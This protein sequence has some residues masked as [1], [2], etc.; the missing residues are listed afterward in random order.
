ME[1]EK[2]HDDNDHGKKEVTIIVNTREKKWSEKEISYKQVVIL[3]FDVFSEDENVVYTVTFTRGEESRH[4]G[5]LV[6]GESVKVKEGMIFNV[7]QT[8]KS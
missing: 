6:K 3:A 4:E 2:K 7:T 8:N 5:S 1:N